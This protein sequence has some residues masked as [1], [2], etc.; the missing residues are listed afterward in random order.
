MMGMGQVELIIGK[1]ST[2]IYNLD[3]LAT[4]PISPFP[5]FEC[6]KIIILILKRSLSPSPKN[7][8]IV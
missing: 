2:I 4:F 8:F 1:K 7:G 6:L 3:V 5:T